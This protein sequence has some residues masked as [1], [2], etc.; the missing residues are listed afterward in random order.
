MKASLSL[1]IACLLP[2]SAAH[3]GSA[4]WKPNATSNDW[5]TAEN[6]TPPTI[7]STETDVATF[8]VS[9]TT[10]VLCGDAPGGGGTTTVIGDI[11]FAAGSSAYTIT[12]TPVSDNVFPSI[13]EVHG[14]GITNNSGVVQNLVAANSGTWRA[15]GRIYFMN[16]SSAGEN[17]II[18]NE[19]GASATGDGVYGAFTDIGYNFDDT[20]SAGNATFVNK[21][22]EVSGARGGIT[23]IGIFS[24]GG[25]ESAT[26]INDPGEVSGGGAGFTLI[27]T[28][29]DIGNSTF[30]C[31]PATVTGAE[32][33]W[34][35]FD[36]GTASGANFIANGAASAGPQAGQ[37]YVYGADGY[38]TFTGNGGRG[39]GAEGGLIDLFA[40]PASEQTLVI[41]K[42]GTNGLGGTILIEGEAR[43]G[44]GTVSAPWQ[45]HS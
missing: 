45:W 22:G 28:F 1:L 6:W 25:A 20:A 10:T 11:I 35:E 23:G 33:G 43:G 32:G 18:T 38:A 36:F 41:V 4:T 2:F 15:S 30:I 16:S 42:G 21:G 13:I 34:A 29:G 12:V 3:A 39:S 24:Y 14:G 40:L 31:N 8:A 44:S 26:F 19:G 37:V 27:Q 17:V 7:P 9:N 5:N